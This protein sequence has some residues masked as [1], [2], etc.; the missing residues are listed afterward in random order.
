MSV[1]KARDFWNQARDGEDTDRLHFIWQSIGELL[2]NLER[3]G[4]TP[5]CEFDQAHGY[6]CTCGMWHRNFERL[7]RDIGY[8]DLSGGGAYLLRD[9]R[10]LMVAYQIT[11]GRIVRE[12]AIKSPADPTAEALKILRAARERADDRAIP[13][14]EAYRILDEGI[15]RAMAALRGEPYPRPEPHVVSRPRE[16]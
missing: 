16:G 7:K 13:H 4:H 1:P 12:D 14:D 10:N 8:L 5:A 11:P 6:E 3:V 2:N 15:M 9:V